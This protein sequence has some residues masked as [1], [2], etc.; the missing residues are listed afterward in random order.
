MA[1]RFQGNALGAAEYYRALASEV[2]KSL[3]LFWGRSD[4]KYIERQFVNRI[5]NTLERLGDCNLL[6]DPIHCDLAEAVD[7]YRR[8][9]SFTPFLRDTDERA[10]CEAALYFKQALALSLPSPIQDTELALEICQMAEKI[11]LPQAQKAGGLW[12]ALGELTPATVRLLDASA[13]R[14]GR[15][16]VKRDR[17]AADEL[18]QKIIAY[19]DL[20]GR[21]PHR[22][23]LELS[24]FS[25]NVLVSQGDTQSKRQKS[26]DADLLLGF[27][28]LAL[29]HNG[30]NH[31]QAGPRKSESQD[32][33]RP[34]FDSVV[35]AKLFDPT[36]RAKELI[37][38]HAE[39]TLGTHY[40]KPDQSI[41]KLA[42]Y[43]L[44]Q[45][46]YLVLDLP[47]G[48]GKCLDLSE[49]YDLQEI[50]A[51][52]KVLP[53]PREIHQMLVDWKKRNLFGS[54]YAVA[55]NSSYYQV[56][57]DRQVPTNR[58]LV[59]GH[60]PFELPPGFSRQT[61]EPTESRSAEVLPND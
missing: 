22:D 44:G 45:K 47:N 15:E 57:T 37:E 33:L 58:A 50:Q 59:I 40:V 29:T 34:Y 5:I 32:Y 52:T 61:L 19:R 8:A 26:A 39:A 54:H 13:I 51:S 56:P 53:L 41:P 18:R 49:N 21:V 46:H 4:D 27:C 43:T 7:D 24:L 55:R 36:P 35:R 48:R 3:F 14:H 31:R 28:R 11:Y 23:Q 10:K 30:E 60:F 9:L 6:S 42:L 20:I 25:A 12:Q 2:H 17:T 38:I 1:T 16:I